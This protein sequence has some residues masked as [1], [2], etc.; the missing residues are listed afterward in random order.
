M[1]T[2][3]NPIPVASALIDKTVDA[4]GTMTA[5]VGAGASILT[6]LNGAILAANT[7]LPSVPTFLDF[8][9]TIKLGTFAF[10]VTLTSH[11]SRGK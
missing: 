5:P 3:P 11:F 6:V 8:D 9:A 7:V 1:S 4:V 10:L 2:T